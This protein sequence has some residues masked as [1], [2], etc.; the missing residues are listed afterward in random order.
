MATT[1]TT[2]RD[3]FE[4]FRAALERVDI[5]AVVDLYADDAVLTSYSERDRPS[6]AQQIRDKAAIAERWREV[7]KRKLSESITDEVIGDNRFAATITCTYP[8]GE[9]V[10]GL[11]I[12]E[13]RDGKIARETSVEAWDE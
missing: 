2:T 10:V 5:D 4:A 9:K 3:T 8:T 6:S 1:A 11:H 12:F 7:E 13:L